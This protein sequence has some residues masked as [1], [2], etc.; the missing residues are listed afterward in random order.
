MKQTRRRA[1]TSMSA[2]LPKL[3]NWKGSGERCETDF[4]FGSYS[5][6]ARSLRIWEGLSGKPNISRFYRILQHRSVKTY[7]VVKCGRAAP[8]TFKPQY[9]PH[10]RGCF[11]QR[12]EK[13]LVKFFFLFLST[14]V[15][16][17]YI[18]SC[19]STVHLRSRSIL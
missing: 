18:Q 15:D 6:W 4:E 1:T 5:F 13:I 14:I 7:T 3:E 17:H 11:P 16:Q 10:G 19:F 9:E 12:T 8:Q 2:E